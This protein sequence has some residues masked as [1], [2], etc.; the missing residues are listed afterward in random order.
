MTRLVVLFILLSCLNEAASQLFITPYENSGKTRTAT[1]SEC[2]EWYRKLHFSYPQITSFDSIGFSDGGNPIY[3]FRIFG[4]EPQ[5]KIRLLI[6]NNIHPGE[7]EG[8]DASMLLA[9]ELLSGKEGRLLNNIDLHIICQ[10]NTDGTRNQSCCTRANQDGPVNQGFRA[11]ARNLDLNRDFI[12]CDSRNAEAFVQYF[13]KNRFDY[14]IDNHTSNGADYQYVLTYFHT[15]QEK[16]IPG[17]SALIEQVDK[18]L[19][20]NLSKQGWPTAPYVETVKGVPDSGIF[21]FWESG[22]YATGFAALNHCMGFTVETH[23]LKPFPQRVDATLAFMK[24]FMETVSQKTGQAL[25]VRNHILRGQ[26]RKLSGTHYEPLQFRADMS[27]FDTILFRGYEYGY[28]T[29]PVTGLPRLY[30]DRNKPWMKPVR[31]Y[32]YFTATDSAKLPRYYVIPSAWHEVIERLTANG[33]YMSGISS[34]TTMDMRMSYIQKFETV[35]SPYEGHY[36]HYNIQSRDTLISFKIHRGDRLVKVTESNHKFLAA[37]LEPRAPDSYFA[38][39]FFDAILQQKE[40]YSEYVWA[41]KAEELLKQNP[42]LKKRFE[43]KK[44]ADKE[45]SGNASAQFDWI[46]KNSAYYERT[47]R[48]YPVGRID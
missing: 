43:A 31:Y 12:K 48:L 11:N 46:Y 23:M 36:L 40:G 1:Y 16:L 21:A 39:N 26:Q 38:W 25:E 34:D 6:M 33:I 20:N 9:R 42:D 10:Y 37:V 41:D 35:G 44:A 2:T 4:Q 45:F 14:F 32:R 22:R 15:R 17:A 3:V 18:E 24:V 30:Y 47:H 27:R 29:S 28:K 19:K 8:T 7:P 5:S 13:T